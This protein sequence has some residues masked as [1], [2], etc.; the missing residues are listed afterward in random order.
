MIIE[1]NVIDREFDVKKS[2]NLIVLYI[3]DERTKIMFHDNIKTFDL[4]INFEMIRDEIFDI[5]A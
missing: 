1:K 5:D 3:I 4:F 2:F